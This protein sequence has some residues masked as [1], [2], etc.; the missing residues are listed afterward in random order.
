MSKRKKHEDEELPFVA[1]MDTMT[2]VVGVLIIVLV[3][4][5]LGMSSAVKKI[6]SDLPS[7][8][9]ATFE[10]TR[11][12]LAQNTVVDD[13]QKLDEQKKKIEES[14]KFTTE[15]L[16]TVDLTAEAQKVKFIDLE[17]LRKQIESRTKERDKLKAD[18]Q[19]LLAD[20]DKVKKLLDETP[21]YVAPAA[22]VVKLPNPRA[23][24]EKPNEQRILVA[25]P[26]VVLYSEA[27]IIEPLLSGLEKLKPQIQYRDALYPPFKKLVEGILPA[28]EAGKAWQ[29]IGGLIH[30]AQVEH[31]AQAYGS[32]AKAGLAP[33]RSYLQALLD[34]G[35]TIGATLPQMA[36]ATVAAG[37]GDFAPWLALDPGAKR[38]TPVMKAQGGAK[39]WTF[40][41]GSL[42]VKT[43]D[44]PAGFADWIKQLSEY[45]PF[46]D[47]SKGSVI[48][49]GVKLKQAL[50]RAFSNPTFSR[51]FSVEVLQRPNTAFY[52]L[53]LTPSSGAGEPT[54]VLTAPDSSFQRSLRKL[55]TDPNGVA[56]FQ[57]QP[58]AFVTYLTAREVADQIGVPA[59]WEFLPTLSVEYRLT[60]YPIQR[61]E[62][63]R[64][65]P[66]APP[67]AAG[68]VRIAAPGRSL[69]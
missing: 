24:P 20:L 6:L 51:G 58:D 55:K 27:E 7:V 36:E 28:A 57:V 64:V 67:G 15:E 14:I 10:K 59:A 21:A 39:E 17:E 25:K 1:L 54:S 13:P 49:D 43:K 4:V 26:G 48:Y 42:L 34:V 63:L 8:D 30:T 53:I 41:Y 22:T 37:R 45:G 31:L 60:A 52:S 65:A 5:G 50:E 33:T 9:Q 62:P 16:K 35:L 69:D 66:P 12:E 46:K 40:A 68:A 3:L 61:T 11:E 19:K 2:N 23:Y 29:E 56:L 47:K 32:M 38:G 18:A 44:G